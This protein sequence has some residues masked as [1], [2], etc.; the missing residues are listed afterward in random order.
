MKIKHKETLR[1]SS[2]LAQ[3]DTPIQVLHFT[4][5]FLEHKS[6]HGQDTTN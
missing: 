1:S 2:L 5:N 4:W 6:N 3:M